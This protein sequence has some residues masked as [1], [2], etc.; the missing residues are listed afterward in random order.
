MSIS[1]CASLF[2]GFDLSLPTNASK[3]MTWARIFYQDILAITAYISKLDRRRLAELHDYIIENQKVYACDSE[4]LIVKSSILVD[5]LSDRFLP[6]DEVVHCMF[7]SIHSKSVRHRMVRKRCL[8]HRVE[9]DLS[10]ALDRYE[11]DIL[12]TP[13]PTGAARQPRIVSYASGP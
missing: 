1:T 5:S 2:K 12:Q 7:E 11:Q 4:E 13:T 8:Q 9:V 6:M 3:K 10:I